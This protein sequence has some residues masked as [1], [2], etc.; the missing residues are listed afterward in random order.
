MAT[1]I[2]AL[3]GHALQ[4][5]S[6]NPM[7]G[8]KLI[9]EISEAHPAGFTANALGLLRE[10]AASSGLKYLGNHLVASGKLLDALLDPLRFEV[11]E[12]EK[13]IHD[14]PA[15]RKSLLRRVSGILNSLE[16]R[17]LPPETALRLLAILDLVLEGS[18]ASAGLAN[19]AS[20]AGGHV[21]SK[22]VLMMGRLNHNLGWLEA[23]LEDA[24]P[25]V[26]ANA[27]EA[28]WGLGASFLPVYR[29]AVCDSSPRVVGNAIFG[30]HLGGETA[31]AADHAIEL[32]AHQSASFRATAAWVMGA[33][34]S[35]VFIECLSRLRADP[36]SGVRFRALHAI[37]QLKNIPAI[38]VAKTDVDSR[39][40]RESTSPELVD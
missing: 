29:D 22:A 39:A 32:A 5:F 17:S 10:G 28:T 15:V 30:L 23:K 18:T 12:V 31:E 8:A 34:G 25:R 13:L 19:L 36:A 11:T 21:R 3:I 4:L 35:P 40:D 1:D 20:H 16:A 2:P 24:D 9:R 6:T 27:I 37:R 33:I 7:A 38:A 14:L 26:R